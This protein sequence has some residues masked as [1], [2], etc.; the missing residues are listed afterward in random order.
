[1]LV[2]LLRAWGQLLSASGRLKPTGGR[3]FGSML[4]LLSE[5]SCRRGYAPGVGAFPINNNGR[6]QARGG[7]S[8]VLTVHGAILRP[9]A[10][11]FAAVRNDRTTASGQ[12]VA[13]FRVTRARQLP[14]NTIQ[15]SRGLF[16]LGVVSGRT[17]GWAASGPPAAA[18][19]VGCFASYATP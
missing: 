9:R 17:P 2:S 10:F 3:R 16:Y 1:M 11:L 19:P 12:F 4:F 6:P 15:A 5:G 7:V 8:Q 18:A 14:A 13:T